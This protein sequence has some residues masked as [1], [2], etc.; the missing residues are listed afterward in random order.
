MLEHIKEYGLEAKA[1][2]ELRRVTR[3]G[4]IVIIA[5]PSSEL[6]G[7]HGFHF[8]EIKDLVAARFR[9]YVIFE[10]ALVPDGAER[11]RIDQE[12]AT[13]RRIEADPG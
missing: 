9:D 7:D 12:L 2:D 4:G 8:E 5:T 3:A 6:L 11:D 1:L 13:D 10:N